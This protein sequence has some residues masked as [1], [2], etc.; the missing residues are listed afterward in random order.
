MV[1]IGAHLYFA[2]VASFVVGTI[3]NVLLLRRYF[4]TGRHSLRKDLALS[5][6][7]NGI[8]ILLAMAVYVALMSLLGLHHLIA[9]I[10][11]NGISFLV[12]YRVRR[13]YF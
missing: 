9:K 8:V 4:A 13:N 3:C 5:L 11:A 6:A 7:S 10:I 1:A 12:N 2:F